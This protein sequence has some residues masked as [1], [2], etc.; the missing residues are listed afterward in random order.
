VALADLYDNRDQLW[1]VSEINNVNFYNIP[2]VFYCTDFHMDL[3][4][5]RYAVA[6]L[7]AEEPAWTMNPDK[8]TDKDFTT[9]ALRR[10]G[11]R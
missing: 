5:G 7:N 9:Q 11:R 2:V 3:Q 1:R 8:Y 4:A 10:M 6:W